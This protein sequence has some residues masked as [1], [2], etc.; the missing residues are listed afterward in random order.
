MSI[1]KDENEFEGK[2]KIT[3]FSSKK[4][5]L[6]GVDLFCEKYSKGEKGSFYDIEKEN[7][8]LLLLNFHKN[9]DLASFVNNKLKLLQIE[10]INFSEL[11]SNLIIKIVNPKNEKYK[12]EKKEK[13]KSKE[14]KNENE[15]EEKQIKNKRKQNIYIKN[16]TKDVYNI[17]TKNNPRLNKLLNKSLNFNKKNINK[18]MSPVNNK[19][20]IYESIFFG[21]PYIIQSDLIKEENRKNKALWLNKKGFMPYISKE[22]I[23][24]NEHMIGNIL[25]KEPAQDKV[26]PF[27]KVQK[28][29]WVAK[30]DFMAYS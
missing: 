6:D 5:I 9:S 7:A 10:D 14:K 24:K 29:K 26:Y 1:N 27:R 2:I 22:T 18:Y 23:L 13:S 30:N 20:K 8:N 21:G 4:D 16:Y 3:N 12:Q 11:N 19:M 25:Y 28:S 15:K 17:D